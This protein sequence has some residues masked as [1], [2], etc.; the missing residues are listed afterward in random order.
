MYIS[1]AVLISFVFQ[2]L[3]RVKS[4]ELRRSFQSYAVAL[5]A[6]PVFHANHIASFGNQ[7]LTEAD[8]AKHRGHAIYCD[9]SRERILYSLLL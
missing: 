7:Y 8:D 6:H 4:S 1:P 5:V 9:V 2:Q 3:G